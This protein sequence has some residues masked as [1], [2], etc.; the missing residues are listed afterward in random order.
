MKRLLIAM[1]LACVLASTALA[2][3]MPGVTPKSVSDEVPTVGPTIPP[4]PNCGEMPGVDPASAT[5]TEV[6]IMTNALLTILT[7]LGR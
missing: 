4:V 2:G 6:S 3:E 1:T 5:T 7:L